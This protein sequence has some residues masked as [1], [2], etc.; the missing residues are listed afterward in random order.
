MTKHYFLFF[1]LFVTSLQGT[2]LEVQERNISEATSPELIHDK[3]WDDGTSFFL[4]IYGNYGGFGNRGGEA[5]DALDRVFQK[6]DYRYGEYGFLDAKSD[7]RLLEEILHV[8]FYKNIQGEGYVVGPVVFIFFATS[9]P[10]LYRIEPIGKGIILPIP[11]P[12]TSFALF[13]YQVEK[14]YEFLKDKER[15]NSEYQRLKEQTE[16]ANE[17]AGDWL[18][19][20]KDDAEDF[21]KKVF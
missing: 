1:I 19:E 2:V 20:Q 6:H 8:L 14:A 12:N 9:L 10:S 18:R 5:R 4:K 16:E 17:D 11:V 13:T 15:V 3:Y 21:F 7:A